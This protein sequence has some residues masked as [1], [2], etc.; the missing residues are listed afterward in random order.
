MAI[1]CGYSVGRTT[2]E[3][4]LSDQLKRFKSRKLGDES[5]E[6][7]DG[8]TNPAR[9]TLK[10]KCID[11]IV[12][13]FAENPVTEVIPP[14]QM[15]EITAKLP[16]D[17]SPVVG[18]KYV[19]N[20]AYW[21]RCCVDKF[22]WHK[23]ELSEHGLLWKQV[24]FEKLMQERLEDFNPPSDSIH[25]LEELVVACMDYIFT[26]T[27][28]QLPSHLDMHALCN[29]LPNLTKLDISYGVNKIGMEYERMLFGMKISDA[30]NLAKVFESTQTLSTLIIS[31]NMIDDD[32]LRV[33]M[34]GLIKNNT[35]TH[36][37]VSH[38]KITNH[39]AR[40]L[41]KLLGENSVLATLNVADNH[42]HTEGG[43]YFARGLR[44]NDALLALNL[45]L[46]H[47]GDDGCR[48]LLE[49]LQDN[50]TLTDLNISSNY[51]GAQ[52]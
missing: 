35:I 17:L 50:I 30:T 12:K 44:E 4:S 2:A 36:L 7:N 10:S 16:S 48:L 5:K 46:N 13:N 28:R 25:D 14:A 45:R 33:L 11:I 43:R 15:A 31:G 21:K 19:Y 52:V 9:E 24:Y 39:G 3:S 32:L 23:C 37:D 26:I 27:F 47:L 18:A 20:E 40:L 34:T 22:G 49:G 42:I 51:A 8:P 1:R 41:S 29:L 38:N 6:N